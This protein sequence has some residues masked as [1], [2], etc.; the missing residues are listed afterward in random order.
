MASG[1]QGRNRLEKGRAE[2]EEEGG[3]SRLHGWRDGR[4]LTTK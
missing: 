3:E 1:L 4:G 2:S